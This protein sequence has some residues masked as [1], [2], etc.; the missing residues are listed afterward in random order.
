MQFWNF[1][2]VFCGYLQN[3]NMDM[4]TKRKYFAHL[5][6]A[7][8]L[9][10]VA[11][12]CRSKKADPLLPPTVW[13]TPC[14]IACDGMLPDSLPLLPEEMQVQLFR[15]L[16]NTPGEQVHLKTPYPENWVLEAAVECLY[17]DFDIWIVSNPGEPVYK[18]LLTV[19][20]VWEGREE[21]S[22]ISAVWV[23]YSVANEQKDHI[24]SEEWTA[25]L[26]NDLNLTIHKKY[27]VLHS[28]TDTTQRFHD[29]RE[30]EAEDVFHIA[31]DG[32]ISYEEPMYT[33]EYRAVLQF[34]DTTE[35]GLNMD[36]QWLENSMAMQEVLEQENIL[37]VEVSH[38]FDEVLV[39]SYN[40][41]AVDLVDI[42]AF[43]KTYGQG[44]IVL[45]KGRKPRYVRYCPAAEA[46][47][48]ILPEWGIDYISE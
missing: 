43:T 40:G 21:R 45:E 5:L 36:D 32:S 6:F 20:P 30:K 19:T 37:F 33:V 7:V 3:N 26:D 11:V 16:K 15:Y 9:I 41:E 29:N 24:V 27:E 23:A 46:L 31:S 12:S 4:K 1:V 18:M 34:I 2:S 39:T 48:K 14:R 44:Y 8:C 38:H 28:L 25:D 17:S 42:S 13:D 22:L 47:Q 10:L 35:S